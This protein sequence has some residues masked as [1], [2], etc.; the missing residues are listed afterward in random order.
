MSRRCC[1]SPSLSNCRW[2]WLVPVWR[3]WRWATLWR[4]LSW[5]ASFRSSSR[6]SCSGQ[7]DW[8]RDSRPHYEMCHCRHVAWSCWV[9][10]IRE[11]L[12]RN[13]ISSHIITVSSTINNNTC[14]YSVLKR[15]VLHAQY[16]CTDIFGYQQAIWTFN[17][18][19]LLLL[20][21]G[22]SD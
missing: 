6:W 16:M 9:A 17:N 3:R 12:Q 1:C 10:R 5:K 11:H 14:R 4:C 18:G 21:R 13:G 8:P 2:H 7:V 15:I 19:E 22:T 20:T